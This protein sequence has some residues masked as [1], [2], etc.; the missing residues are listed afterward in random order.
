MKLSTRFV[1]YMAI[2]NLLQQSADE[3]K[4]GLCEEDHILIKKSL[5]EFQGYGAKRLMKGFPTKTIL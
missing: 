3:A 2:F 5:H 1:F 4:M